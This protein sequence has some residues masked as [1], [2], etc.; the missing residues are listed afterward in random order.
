MISANSA[1]VPLVEAKPLARAL[2]AVCR[3]GE[4]I[5]PELYQGVATVLAFLQQVSAS[6][7]AYGGAINLD[8]PDTWTPSGAELVRVPPAR[9]R[10]LEQ[11]AA[12][13]A[14]EQAGQQAGQATTQPRPAGAD[15]A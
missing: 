14:A 15:G 6:R 3:V 11:Q 4:E 9:R 10:M 5:P 1:G 7:R 13:R 8:V 12:Q 2:Y